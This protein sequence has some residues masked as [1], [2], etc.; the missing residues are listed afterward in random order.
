[1]GYTQPPRQRLLVKTLAHYLHEGGELD[2]S[3]LAAH[4]DPDCQEGEESHKIIVRDLEA[5]GR[6]LTGLKSSLGD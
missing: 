5:F 3:E 4:A 2:W 6:I 1:M